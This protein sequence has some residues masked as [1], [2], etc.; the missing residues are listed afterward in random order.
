[1][2]WIGT[3]I[4][5]ITLRML[6]FRSNHCLLTTAELTQILLVRYGGHIVTALRMYLMVTVSL[7]FGIDIVF[8]FHKNYFIILTQKYF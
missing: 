7:R 3:E 4:T 2:A 5:S 8:R 1:M 6:L